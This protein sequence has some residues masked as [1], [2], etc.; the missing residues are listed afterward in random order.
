MLLE[1]DTIQFGRCLHSVQRSVLVLA[2]RFCSQDES[3]NI[4]K[5]HHHARRQIPENGDL[6]LFHR[7][8]LSVQ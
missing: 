3:S 2:L 6:H 7:D 8:R 1:S 4:N 5:Y